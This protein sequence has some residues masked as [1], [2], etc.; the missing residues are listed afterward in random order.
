MTPLQVFE[1]KRENE[2][3]NINNQKGMCVD[4]YAARTKNT[5]FYK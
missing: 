1:F 3:L 4:N 2:I 5:S